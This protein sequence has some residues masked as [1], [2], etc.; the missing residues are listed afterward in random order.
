MIFSTILYINTKEIYLVS[1]PDF[2]FQLTREE[3]QGLITT[4]D[5]FPENIRHTPTPPMAFCEQGVAM[6]SSVLRSQ[7]AI[8]V[9]I[10]IMRAFI[11]VRQIV[12]RRD[13]AKQ[14][15]ERELNEKYVELKQ[16]IEKLK[17]EN[18]E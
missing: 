6:L 11:A 9:N 15:L 4:C 8:Q 7:I 5:K 17:Q 13:E 10:E 3:W 18:E 12:I 14:G 1:P 2:A 16:S